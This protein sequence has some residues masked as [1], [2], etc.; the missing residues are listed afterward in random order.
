MA[1]VFFMSEYKIK[2]PGAEVL[3]RS[4][5]LCV[6]YQLSCAKLSMTR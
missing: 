1:E 4:G 3:F 2:K 5:L 6:L